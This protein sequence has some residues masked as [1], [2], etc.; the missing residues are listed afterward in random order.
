MTTDPRNFIWVSK[1]APKTVDD[2]VLPSQTHEQAKGIVESGKLP[3][4]LFHGPAG[5]GKTALAKALASELDY[6]CI[7]VN[8]SNEGRLLDTLRVRIQ[9]FASSVSFEGKRKVV[10]IDEADYIPAD[11]VQ[12]ALR[13]FIEQFANNCSFVLTCNFPN[14]LLEPIR[15]R[16]V[17]VAF[18]IPADEKKTIATRILNNTCDILD[19]EGVEYEKKAVASVIKHYFPDFRRVLNELQGYASQGK[20]DSGILA[21][22]QS[23]YNE[24]IKY[25]RERNFRDMRHWVGQQASLDINELARFL[26]DNM[27]EYFERDSIPQVVLHLADYQYRASFAADQEINT[28]AMLTSIMMDANF[29]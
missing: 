14:R 16:C 11:T 8:G 26:Y 29:V 27:Y 19:A 28:V 9:E 6:E 13:N 5:T 4:M 21:S 1:H 18:N 25:I 10:I 22:I 23:Q 2:C 12:P 24:V 7:V 15:S 20:I 3:N 17:N